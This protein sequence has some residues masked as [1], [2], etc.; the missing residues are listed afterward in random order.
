MQTIK[1]VFYAHTHTDKKKKNTYFQI[2]QFSEGAY[3]ALP[4][5]LTFTSTL[6]EFK[7]VGIF[8]TTLLA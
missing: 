1:L 4:P 3:F 6:A 5:E 2:I 7:G 8:N